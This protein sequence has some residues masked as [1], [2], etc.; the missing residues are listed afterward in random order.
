[1]I[2]LWPAAILSRLGSSTATSS[3]ND[4]G[5]AG[6]SPPRPRERRKP[7]ATVRDH[8][9]GQSR[10]GSWRMA[11]QL[12]VV[13]DGPTLLHPAPRGE[14]VVALGHSARFKRYGPQFW[15]LCTRC[16]PGRSVPGVAAFRHVLTES[17]DDL[18][19]ALQLMV[20]PLSKICLIEMC[21]RSQPFNVPSLRE[22]PVHHR[23]QLSKV[24]WLLGPFQHPSPGSTPTVSV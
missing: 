1:M 15:G 16:R 10:A 24:V 13:H 12:A 8:I 3:P 23:D 7:H 14:T 22:L 4:G 17:V 11:P 2:R 20:S 18:S 5:G 9:L 6:K 19:G 21:R